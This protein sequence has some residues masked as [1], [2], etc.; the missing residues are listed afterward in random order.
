M[1]VARLLADK[2][3][4]DIEFTETAV[5]WDIAHRLELSFDDTKK[6]MS[7]LQELD[8]TLQ[9][10]MKKFTL[11][12][13]H[14]QLRDIGI[15]MG[16]RFLEFCLFSETRFMQYAHRTYDH[17]YK[18][19]PVL[20]TKI[21]RDVESEG[22]S[23]ELAADREF[24]E[25][26]LAQVT[27]ILN[28]VFMREISHLLTIISKS[29]QKFN[30]LP[31]S[32]MNHFNKLKSSLTRAKEKFEIGEPPEIELLKETP[33]HKAFNLWEDFKVCV[34][35]VLHDQTFHGFKLLLPSERG[36]VTRLV[37]R[38]NSVF[39]CEPVEYVGIVK[40]LFSK[41]SKYIE[42]LLFNLHCCFVPWP[43]WITLCDDSFNFKN[44][45]ENESR[46]ISF[47]KL[48]DQKFGPVPLKDDERTRLLAEYATLLVNVSQIKAKNN[49]DATSS[50]KVWY[51][52]LTNKEYYEACLN[53]NDFALRFL[54]R[55]YN[56]CS[57][58]V[59]VSNMN[60]IDT[61]SRPLKHITSEK[62]LFISS[63]GPHP[64]VSLTLVEGALNLYFK[65][66]K[67]HFVLRDTKYFTSKVVDRRIREAEG[68]ANDLACVLS[69][70]SAYRCFVLL[71][72]YVLFA[73]GAPFNPM[74]TTYV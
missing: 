39:G 65:G 3:S 62:L 22:T 8:T 14:T 10:I 33:H 37:T 70:D 44:S 51:E 63:N 24:S 9:S 36:R 67:W 47:S 48:L 19:H 71:Y 21:R 32:A 68:M 66:N 30:T 23:T 69:K 49:F 40:S 4:L 64:S 27:F 29:S 61:S 18:M 7:W 31:F 12:M 59:E 20:I 5:T 41:F 55:T 26:L 2:L 11:G 46:K 16:K 53:I 42:V 15:E 35:R 52:L 28:L 13:H 17:F 56:E 74:S 43:E 6:Q 57:V 34:D 54:V 38:S 50:E 72:V 58:E 45:V 60:A 1:N 73:N 25:K